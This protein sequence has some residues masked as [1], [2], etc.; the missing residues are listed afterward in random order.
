L[1][2]KKV[3]SIIPF[4]DLEAFVEKYKDKIIIVDFFTVWCGPC[5]WQ[6]ESLAALEQIKELKNDILIVKIDIDK[7]DER[8]EA[9]KIKSIPN[10]KR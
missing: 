6:A 2:G 5:K 8:A 10:G 1:K 7:D 9:L 4:K 3:V